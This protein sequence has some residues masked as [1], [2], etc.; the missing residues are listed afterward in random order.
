MKLLPFDGDEDEKM[1]SM[2]TTA[3][4]ADTGKNLRIVVLTREEPF[5]VP[6]YLDGLFRERAGQI[7]T[8]FVDGSPSPHLGK[9]QIFRLCGP[10]GF[11]RLVAKFA[12]HKVYG[13]LGLLRPNG[14]YYSLAGLIRHY[15]VPRVNGF[16]AHSEVFY[17]NLT[18]L[19]PDVVL[20][21]ANSK[22]LPERVLA[23]PGAVFCNVHG[24]YLPEYRGILTAFWMLHDGCA[25]GGVSIHE[26]TADVDAGDIFGRRAIP[27]TPE[28][29]MVSL[30]DKVAATGSA[31]IT[32]TLGKLEFGTIERTPN[33][34]GGRMRLVPGDE[35][36][37]RF[38]AKGRQ[39]I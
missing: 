12:R 8:V 16:D 24:S 22:I 10:M 28:D 7:A 25:S 34:A 5:F 36:I 38:R 17:N 32:E 26:M 29:T 2:D 19:A 3:P 39:F 13:K 23:L 20:S 35:Q 1:G 15:G 18:E 27:I 31:L 33:P 30:Y 4:S 11:V 21:V 6:V 14:C 9:G 37:R